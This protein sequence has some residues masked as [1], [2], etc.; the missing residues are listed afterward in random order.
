MRAAAKRG[1]RRA[2]RRGRC[3]SFGVVVRGRRWCGGEQRCSG[4][5]SGRRRAGGGVE[6]VR[7][8]AEKRAGGAGKGHI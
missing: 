2:C 1:C 7:A 8:R 5:G 4:G 6:I 3:A